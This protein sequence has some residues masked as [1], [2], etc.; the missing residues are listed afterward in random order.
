MAY[1][2]QIPGPNQA[3]RSQSLGVGIIVAVSVK[4]VFLHKLLASLNVFLVPPRTWLLLVRTLSDGSSNVSIEPD[5]EPQICSQFIDLPYSKL[6]F[7]V[8]A[9]DVML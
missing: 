2:I 8:K 6:Q 4:L 9:C 1:H 3:S 5:Y 7:F